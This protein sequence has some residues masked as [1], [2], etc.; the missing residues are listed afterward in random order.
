MEQLIEST[1]HKADLQPPAKTNEYRLTRDELG[2]IDPV[3]KQIEF[4]QN[5]AQS[6]LRAITRLRGLQGNWQ[7]EGDK[8]IRIEDNG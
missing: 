3:V 7:L 4:L 2:M 6:L 8:L 1:N 5:E